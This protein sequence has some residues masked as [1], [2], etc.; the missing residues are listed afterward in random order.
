MSRRARVEWR[1]RETREYQHYVREHGRPRGGRRAWRTF[2]HRP[3]PPTAKEV[4]PKV[5]EAIR[6][7]RQQGIP[8]DI[9]ARTMRRDLAEP[10]SRR[11]VAEYVRA[12][13]LKV[14]PR[15][16]ETTFRRKREVYRQSRPKALK[17][18]QRHAVES[19]MLRADIPVE[20]YKDEDLKEWLME[21]A[22]GDYITGALW[23]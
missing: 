19:A 5:G 14:P 21:W 11:M 13:G 17:A 7:A 15:N 3:V 10:P 2:V 22:E 20:A 18:Y 6:L 16:Q 9:I 12:H 1:A 23:Y 4:D 8:I